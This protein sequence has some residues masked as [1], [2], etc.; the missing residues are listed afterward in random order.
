M[1]VGFFEC[2]WIASINSLITQSFTIC[3]ATVAQL[4][5]CATQTPLAGSE[6]LISVISSTV[7]STATSIA[8]DWSTTLCLLTN[9]AGVLGSMTP[10]WLPATLRISPSVF[11]PPCL[12]RDLEHNNTIIFFY[13]NNGARSQA[14]RRQAKMQGG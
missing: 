4:T 5:S 1:R 6:D 11:A 14:P 3:S 9:F 2:T 7:S 13:S 10:R 12:F 8:Q